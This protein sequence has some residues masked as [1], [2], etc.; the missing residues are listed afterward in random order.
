[1]D[2]QILQGDGGSRGSGSLSTLE[3]KQHYKDKSQTLNPLVAKPAITPGRAKRSN[4]SSSAKMACVAEG[5]LPRLAGWET[6]R[7]EDLH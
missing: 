2:L 3:S 4:L 5:L 6:S 7:H 1:M